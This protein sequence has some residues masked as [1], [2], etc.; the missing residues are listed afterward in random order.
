VRNRADRTCRDDV[1]PASGC[2]HAAARDVVT[3][4]APAPTSGLDSTRRP[5]RRS[6]STRPRRRNG[7]SVPAADP[8]QH[9]HHTDD[10]GDDE[11]RN[12]EHDLKSRY[13]GSSLSSFSGSDSR[14][15]MHR[16]EPGAVWSA[17]VRPDA[18]LPRLARCGPS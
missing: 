2:T 5:R 15:G 18:P 8:Q 1:G 13:V 7:C 12:Q 9:D 3:E 10:E 4:S 14:G 16:P 17:Q 11:E 6:P